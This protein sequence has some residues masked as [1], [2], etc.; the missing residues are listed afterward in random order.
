MQVIIPAMQPMAP[1]P[2]PDPV[3]SKSFMVAYTPLLPQVLA[4]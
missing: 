3:M 2:I 1:S 4:Q